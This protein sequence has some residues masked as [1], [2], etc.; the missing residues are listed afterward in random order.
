MRV[1]A[2][3]QRDWAALDNRDCLPSAGRALFV[4]MWCL[5]TGLVGASAAWRSSSLADAVFPTG[6]AVSAGLPRIFVGADW[7]GRGVELC[8]GCLQQLL[9]GLLELVDPVFFQGEEDVGEVDADGVQLVE[10]LLRR[11]GGALHRVTGDFAVVGDG[12]ERLLRHRVHG[13]G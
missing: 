4:C 9:P 6:V 7:S 1:A 8:F 13:V 10:D 2:A 5:L 11:R 3:A 12:L